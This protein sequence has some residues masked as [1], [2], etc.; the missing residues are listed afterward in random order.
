MLNKQ[1]GGVLWFRAVAWLG[2]IPE[3]VLALANAILDEAMWI[4][5]G[6][7]RATL[8][9]ATYFFFALASYFILRAVRDAF[10]SA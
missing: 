7:E 1:C 4:E 9:A 6:E 2:T 8:L 5:A 10:G 3:R